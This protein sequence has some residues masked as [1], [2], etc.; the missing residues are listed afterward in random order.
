MKKNISY[1]ALRNSEVT[2]T[3]NFYQELSTKTLKCIGSLTSHD[4]GAVTSVSDVKSFMGINYSALAKIINIL[5]QSGYIT[6]SINSD[7]PPHEIE[8]QNIGPE[9]LKIKLTKE[10]LNVIL[11]NS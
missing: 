10:G 1:S 5:K 3:A 6:L 7:R 4:I 8:Y 9:D 2:S 11:K